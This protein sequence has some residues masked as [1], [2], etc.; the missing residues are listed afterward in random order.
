M[1][2]VR[3]CSAAQ[4]LNLLLRRPHPLM[5]DKQQLLKLITAMAMF[6]LLLN[7]E[8]TTRQILSLTLLEAWWPAEQTSRRL[9]EN[10]PLWPP[11]FVHTALQF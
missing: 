1:S 11:L 8:S 6:S 4:T 2:T 10:A 7:V 9:L 5:Q 3:A